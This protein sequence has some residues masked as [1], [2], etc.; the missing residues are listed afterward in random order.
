MAN[1]NGA[2]R[3]RRSS[4]AVRGISWSGLAPLAA[5]ARYNRDRMGGAWLR[6]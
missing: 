3:G 6:W 5:R 1:R 2:R 4:P